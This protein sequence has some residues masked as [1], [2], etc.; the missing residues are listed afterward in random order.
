MKRVF[1]ILS[2]LASAVTLSANNASILSPNGQIKVD[3]SDDGGKISYTVSLGD[4]QF[5]APSPLGLKLNHIDLTTGM[6]LEKTDTKVIDDTYSVRSL[7]KKSVH[8]VATAAT[9]AFTKDGKKAMDI[10]FRISDTDVAFRYYIHQ[11]EK[12]TRWSAVVKE[13]ITGFNVAEGTT[14]YLAP[15]MQPMT[16]FAGTAPSYETHPEIDAPLGKNG[17]GDG[18]VFPA[19]FKNADKGWMLISETGTNGNYCGCHLQNLGG[20]KYAIAF[21]NPKE[22][23]GNGTSQPGLSLPCATP[24]RTIT[25]GTTPQA[26]VETTVSN[27]LVEQQ[28]EASKDF[29][30]GRGTW[31][32]IQWMDASCNYDDQKTYIDFAAKMGYQSVLIDAFWNQNIGYEKMEEL[33]KYAASKNVGI[34]LWYNSNGYWNH[35]PQGPFNIMHRAVTRTR[36]FNW[37]KKVGIRG[38][39][40]DFFGGDKQ[41]QMQLYE[42]IL[43]DANTAGVMVIFH[44]CTLPRGWERM[45]PNFVACEAVRASE[46]L[47]FGQNECDQEALYATVH[48]FCRNTLGNMDFGGSALNKFY[49]RS[50]EKGTIRRT[51]DVYALATSILFQAPVQHFALTPNNLTDATEWAIDFMKRVPTEW[52]DVK[53]IAG[54]PGKFVILARRTG[55]KWYI[56][57]VNAMKETLNTTISLD[58]FFKKDETIKLYSDNEKLEGSVKPVKVN[59]KKQLKITIPNNG[60]LLIEQ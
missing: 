45:Y 18:Y 37:M 43:N 41:Q 40:V 44:G 56:C 38:I 55:N 32:W 25:L 36:E 54:E 27:D 42:D 52:D 50:N 49:G 30:Y 60:G 59:K 28:Y 29:T 14:S 53:Y 47:H 19:L 24:W 16:G 46:N 15:Q 23:N 6:K 39:K 12:E 5:I 35:A 10:E 57:G 8:Y 2:L 21:P 26:L 31:S 58:G 17:W 11:P 51:S 48:P 1:F 4:N 22:A 13:E 20:S 34:F 7:K 9:L 3:V 33:V